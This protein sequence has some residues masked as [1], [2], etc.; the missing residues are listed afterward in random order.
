MQQLYASKVPIPD[1]MPSCFLKSFYTEL[2]PIPTFGFQAFINQQSVPLDWKQ[3][4]IV[5]IF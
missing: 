2:A 1:G 3:A 4:N 5:S